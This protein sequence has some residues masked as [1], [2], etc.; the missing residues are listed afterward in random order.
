[1]SHTGRAA[2]QNS[3]SLTTSVAMDWNLK[4]ASEW[5]WDNLYGF[6]T[7]TC[8]T[9]KQVKHL[10]PDAEGHGGNDSGYIYSHGCGGFSGSDSGYGSSS[11]SSV[12]A[13]GC[14][15]SKEGLQTCNTVEGLS[16]DYDINEKHLSTVE[17]VENVSSVDASASSGEHVIGLKLG[18]RTYFGDVCTTGNG[19]SSS[20]SVTAN[21]PIVV[22]KRS[23][24][25]CQSVQSPCCQVEGC[26]LD[27]KSAKDYHR[28]HRICESH[29]KSPKVVV[30][31]L[32]RR[33]CQQCSRFH[34]LS[35]F[36]DKKRSCRRRLSDHN[37]RR[38]RPQPEAIQFGSTLS[39]S[40]YD[41]RR[42]MNVFLNRVALPGKSFSWPSGCGFKFTQPGDSFL[43]CVKS[44]GTSRQ[45]SNLSNDV[46]DSASEAQ[47]ISD[48]GLSFKSSASQMISE[49]LEGSAL[50]SNLEMNPN[51]GGAL[52]LL[53]TTSWGLNEPDSAAA[54]LDQ[55]MLVSDTS[56]AHQTLM[57]AEPQSWS[58]S[59][60]A[61]NAPMEEPPQDSRV[62][63]FDLH[64]HGNVSFQQF[65]HCKTPYQPGSFYSNQMD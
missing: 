43:K 62:N 36:D 53:S 1:M 41:N 52:S 37:A 29:S 39:T 11:K 34:Q 2:T 51:F 26:N 4:S 16:N 23:R 54:A 65:Q 61:T 8:G 42:Q 5:D 38:R 46:H 7:K 27:L 47:L 13:S 58:L 25:S 55:L 45:M 9:Q 3:P 50:T 17:N 35:E 30:A 28:R 59:P 31:G 44:E 56:M 10:N 40:I 64:E 20:F 60:S 21:S 48:K 32:E 24:A 63:S 33:F 22:T 57:H 15:S 14:S 49:G 18:K 19:K 12:S 6:S